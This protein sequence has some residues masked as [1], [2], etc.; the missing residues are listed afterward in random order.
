MP[1]HGDGDAGAG[2]SMGCPGLVDVNVVIPRVDAFRQAKAVSTFSTDA[3][4]PL[5]RTFCLGVESSS[6]MMPVT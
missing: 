5:R 2:P 4:L 1:C 3:A 6:S